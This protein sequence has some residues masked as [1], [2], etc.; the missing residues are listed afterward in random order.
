MSD[1]INIHE[2]K[3]HFAKLLERVAQGEEVVIA[4]GGTPIAKLVP[5]PVSMP[6]R[7]PR[8]PGGAEGLV[9]S[10]S[11]F[12]PLPAELLTHFE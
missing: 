2:A 5:I 3:T 7:E 8:M 9:V 11:F 12:E 4:E 6:S 1:S 10:D